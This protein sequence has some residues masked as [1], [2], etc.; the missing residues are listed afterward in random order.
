MP[1]T[2]D[3]SHNA[4]NTDSDLHHAEFP[5]TTI[6]TLQ[7]PPINPPISPVATRKSTRTGKPT[8]YLR[9]YHC[10]LASASSVTQT[11]SKVLYLI[12]N[13]LS[14]D[15]LSCQHRNYVLNLSFTEEPKSYN[16]AVLFKYWR[17]AMEAKISALI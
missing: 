7:S 17:K 16:Q 4:T 14:Y 2:L 5:T 8:S 1:V 9:D 15:K 11:S 6:D 12:S 13:H 3:S 10:T